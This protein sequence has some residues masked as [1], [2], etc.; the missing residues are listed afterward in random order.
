MVLLPMQS[1]TWVIKGVLFTRWSQKE[2]RCS[3][4][5]KVF[6]NSI[7]SDGVQNHLEATAASCPAEVLTKAEA[8]GAPVLSILRSRLLRRTGAVALLRRM[9]S[10]VYLAIA[11]RRR[12][13]SA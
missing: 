1:V 5:G 2:S 10:R 7:L 13:A 9:E 11:L 6:M 4:K 12:V 3:F 8:R